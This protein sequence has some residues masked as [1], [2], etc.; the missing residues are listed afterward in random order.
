MLI[1]IEQ[2]NRLTDKIKKNFFLKPQKMKIVYFVMVWN[3][4]V[5]ISVLGWGGGGDFNT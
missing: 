3:I 2:C 4:Q 5:K 1:L